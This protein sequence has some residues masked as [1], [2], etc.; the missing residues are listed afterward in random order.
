[1]SH[2]DIMALNNPGTWGHHYKVQDDYPWAPKVRFLELRNYSDGTDGNAH[3]GEASIREYL[4]YTRAYP[5]EVVLESDLFV[6]P[7]VQDF[8]RIFWDADTPPGTRLEVRTRS[9]DRI[10]RIVN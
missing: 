5:A 2:K 3:M 6:L 9:G 7:S 8:G 10:G 4:L 1:M